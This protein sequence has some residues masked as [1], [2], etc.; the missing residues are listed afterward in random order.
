MKKIYLLSGILFI[1]SVALHA[2][3]P[4][5]RTPKTIVADV[6]AQM[7]AQQTNQYN[8]MIK[9]LASTGEE[10]VLQLVKMINPPGKGS[11]APVEYALSGLSHYVSA[12]GQ[13]ANRMVVS[14]AYLKVLDMVT[15]REIK[16][17]IIRQLEITGKDEAINKLFSYLDDEQLSGPAAQALSSIG[18]RSANVGPVLLNAFD[19]GT[20]SKSK[21]DILNAISELKLS[22]AEAPLRKALAGTTDTDTSNAILIALSQCGSKSSLKDLA[23]EAQKINFDIDV[24][25]TTEA[26]IA[27]IKRVLSQGDIKE[28]EKAASD[29]MKNAEKFKLNQVREAALQIQMAAKPSD[30]LKLTQ[31]ALKDDS[32]DYRF[33]ALNF[34][35]AY[36]DETFYKEL[37]K[38]YSKD[39]HEVKI[40]ILNW[41]SQESEN[42]SKRSLIKNIDNKLLITDISGDNFTLKTAV[43]NLISKIGG[44][45]GISVLTGMLNSQDEQTVLLAEKLLNTMEGDISSPV[46][47]IIPSAPDAGKIA[48]LRLLGNR[49]S[50]ANA[51]V[52]ID[53]AKGG[54]SEVRKAAYSVLKDVASSNDLPTLYN[55]LENAQPD[56]LSPIQQAISSAI[57]G[58]PADKQLDLLTVQMNKT[59]KNKQYLYYPVLASTGDAKALNIISD[60]FNKETGVAKDAAF[61]A[62]LDWKSRDV[63]KQL[64]AICKDPSASAYFDKALKRYIQLAS[65]PDLSGNDKFQSLNEAIKLSKTDEQKNLILTQLGKTNTYQGMVLAGKYLDSKPV[66]QAAAQ[67]VMTIAL[68]NKDFY[69]KNVEDLL[70]K[71]ME[72]L[73]N[74]DAAYQRQ[75]IRDHLAS[76]V[77]PDPYQLTVEEKKDGFKILFDGTNMDQWTGN[78]VDYM[79]ENGCISLHP[80]NGH[81]GNL[82]TKEEFGNFIFRFEFQ[83]TPAAN[84]GL[85]I[86]TPMD[87]DAAYHGMELQILDN[88]AP[89]YSQLAK[90]QYHGSV[91]G[92]IA[93]E[94]GHLKPVGE[95]NY[96]E[97]IANGDNIKVILN[98]V[99]ILDGNIRKATKNGMPDKRDHP[100]LFN[101]KGYIGFLGHG[102]PVKFKN[103]RIKPLN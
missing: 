54:S 90:Y 98:G 10:G 56:V 29:L 55:L 101:K 30:V 50:S 89:V 26:Y 19:K 6:L 51:Q 79:I 102:S 80:S 37:V 67:A 85:G 23:L 11:N 100:G 24:A 17:F 43:A 27:L 62:M 39:N 15:D 12:D 84:N 69:G 73:D 22:E 75:A 94:R 13:D 97:V 91:Y 45:D 31:K 18:K 86:R 88:D 95:W 28:A 65:T 63:A 59:S 8:S 68:A 14:N 87:V 46:A 1:C 57:K 60:G 47:A 38:T 41:L 25:G 35:S 61:Q 81:G 53:Q 58:M 78:T 83:L 74:P 71:V 4:T 48:G 77:I 49:K 70:N 3:Y 66:Q 5:N 33:A 2:Q 42:A 96:Q 99:V 52:V 44:N 64:L 93:A 9:D 34:A 92:I 7:P 82:Y 21:K 103:I 76:L 16:A 36:A 40:D 20:N 72:V 32:R